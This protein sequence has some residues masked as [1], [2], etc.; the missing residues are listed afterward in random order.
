MSR[1]NPTVNNPN[2]ATRWFEWNGENG[3]VKYYDKETK[4]S[5]AVGDNFTFILLD[6]L[7]CVKGWHDAS[8][9]GIHSN[10]VKDTRAETLVVKSF[11]GGILAEG[12]Y[13]DIR[14]RVAAAG[15][16]FVANCYIAF[17]NGEELVLG[18]I[19]FKGA[20]LGSWMEF[21]KANRS[22]VYKKAV[23]IKGSVEGKKGR[24][25]F[26]TPIFHLRDISEETNQEAVALDAALQEYLKGYF[27]RTRV[28]QTEKVTQYEDYSQDTEREPEPEELHQRQPEPQKE[29]RQEPKPQATADME[30]EDSD[31]P[32]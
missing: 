11:K 7:G 14:D 19:Q 12:L 30:P 32:F 31:I 29:R 10:E 1:S 24:I 28:E 25:V 23:Q 13:K 2:P 15:G 3:V 5:V 21:Q 27:A 20:A 6:E 8:E 18:S 26:K 17:R 22:E 4:K 9:S 16:Q